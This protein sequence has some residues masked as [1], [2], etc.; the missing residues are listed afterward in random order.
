MVPGMNRWWV[1]E[2]ISFES[3]SATYS[4]HCTPYSKQAS[5]PERIVLTSISPRQPG[6]VTHVTLLLE[7][8]WSIHRDESLTCSIA[9]MTRT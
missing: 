1:M 8:C 7:Y 4:Q 5:R 2:D 3:L 9:L 6:F